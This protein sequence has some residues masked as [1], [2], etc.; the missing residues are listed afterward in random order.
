LSQDVQ[1]KASSTTMIGALTVLWQRVLQ[2]EPIGAEEN[3]F[4]LGGDS[5]LAVELLNEVSK[6]CGRDLPPVMIYQTPTIA[7]L[8][9]ILEHV[10][11]PRLP[12][13]CATEARN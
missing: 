5:T 3:F 1:T 2:R 8:A 10:P 13:S 6:L 9:E 7:L 11:V 4:D 12:S